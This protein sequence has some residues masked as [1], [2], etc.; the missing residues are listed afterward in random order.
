M[1]QSEVNKLKEFYQTASSEQQ[2]EIHNWITMVYLGQASIVARSFGY[3]GFEE[4]YDSA[5]PSDVQPHIWEMLLRDTKVQT[6]EDLAAL[7]SAEIFKEHDS[8]YGDIE[9]EDVEQSAGGEL[10]RLQEAYISKLPPE[11]QQSV[12][13]SIQAGHEYAAALREHGLTD[14]GG[15]ATPDEIA[16]DCIRLVP[17]LDKDVFLKKF[18]DY[19][20]PREMERLSRE[21][22]GPFRS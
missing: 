8:I 7:A 2:M 18:H 3:S 6:V 19:V 9:K 4:L 5:I 22:R 20:G 17:I 14:P 10:A 16:Q 11:R 15:N 1:K 12:R 21:R 13:E